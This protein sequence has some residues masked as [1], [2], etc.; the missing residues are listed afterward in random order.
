MKKF[1]VFGNP[2]KHSLS[3]TIHRFFSRQTGI[4]LNYEAV[5]IPT[6]EFERQVHNFF[7]TGGEGLNITLPYKRR[8]WQLADIKEES[9]RLT[10][11]ANTLS[12][13]RDGIRAANTDGAGLI[14][15]LQQNLGWQLEG[16][17]IA[18]LGAGGAARSVLP[19][20]AAMRPKEIILA[21]RTLQRARRLAR[22]FNHLPVSYCEPEQLGEK[23]YSLL[24]N[25]TAA[26]LTGGVEFPNS[27]I[28]SQLRCYD[29]VY[30]KEE[31]TAFNKWARRNGA[32]AI[33][34]GLGMLIEQ[35]ALSYKIWH[36]VSPETGRLIK[37]LRKSEI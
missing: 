1:A 24:L 31:E 18:L 26:G 5:Y 15:D 36:K 35:A 10:K 33:A 3:P 8:A 16:I 2:I 9:A 22:D 4:N 34:D 11:T 30:N 13:H 6:A 19:A 14:K 21:N 20:L 28:R 25:A 17:S 12:L 29:M 27:I 37:E 7:A 23:D 32:T